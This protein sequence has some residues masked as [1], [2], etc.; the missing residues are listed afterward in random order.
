[1]SPTT[2]ND[3]P[4]QVGTGQDGLESL[5]EELNALGFLARL[6]TETPAGEPPQL[7]VFYPVTSVLRETV[8]ARAGQLFWSWGQPIGPCDQPA[9]TAAAMA[10]VLRT[11]AMNSQ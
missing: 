8:S 11:E 3:T 6:E 5:A 9:E 2:L 7:T 10:L 4:G 1:M